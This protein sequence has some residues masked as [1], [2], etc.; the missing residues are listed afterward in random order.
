[1]APKANTTYATEGTASKGFKQDRQ[2]NWRNFLICS[3]IACGQLAFGYPASI[4]GVTLAQPS[5]LIYMK[6]LDITTDPPSL[7]H[8]ADSLIGAMSG[9]FQAGAF[10]GV[11]IGSFVMDKWGRKAGTIFC[12]TLSIIGGAGL[13]GSVNTT[14]FI[15]FRLIAGAGSWGFLALTPVYC[16]ELA[17]PKLRGFF[18]GM[19]GMGITLGYSLAS[20]MGLAFY[21]DQS[22]P[23]AQWRGPLGLALIFP[24]FQLLVIIWAPESPRYL[25][26]KGKVE[27]AR[28]IVLH[29]HH[30]PGDE[31]QEY[32][33]GE[34]Y[35]M[36][37]QAEFDRSLTPT[38]K[39]MFF[40]KSYRKR[41]LMAC[42]FAFV[43]QST[44][45]LVINNYG[46]TLYA[47]LGY[48]TL[49]QLKLQ[50]GWITMG[51]PANLLG[52]VIMD[53]V[54]RRVL[55][56]I[57]VFGCCACLIV[58]A[59]IIAT[60]ASPIPAVPNLPALKAGVA[61][62]YIF[63][64]FYGCGIDVAGVVFYSEIFPN[65]LRA[66]G[67]AMSIGA[68]ALTDLVYLQVT[69][70]AFAN[71]GWKFFL[72]FI[73]ISGLG[74]IVAFIYLP[75]TKGVPL[76]EIAAIFGD[77]DEVMVFSEDIHVDH[78]THDLVIDV[79]TGRTVDGQQ[80]VDEERLQRVAT[81]GT[82]PKQAPATE[83]NHC[84]G[85]EHIDTVH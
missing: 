37:K 38:Y 33:R 60:F 11:I 65:H 29:I 61:V 34:F 62:F 9:V 25:L 49:D 14:M 6:L 8:N 3:A 69:A 81:E 43:G 80:V 20:Y 48:G 50:C 55:M 68:I 21:Y 30:V 12:S 59:A 32:A 15:I 64:L 74:G 63:L 10:V 39:A 7:V 26:M 72:V 23:S 58:E 53:R 4:I 16:A 24:V 77:T 85:P 5:F 54:G 67:V 35:Q 51:T 83:K 41:T 40:K 28:K 76:E 79:R 73:I 27:E 71:I 57:G 44:A 52:A 82:A 2:W 66:K 46:P 36:Q 84:E 56:L 1:M 70:T 19:N 47:A 78:R 42:G 13:A 22:N 17:P 31:D 75:E 18:V 45:V